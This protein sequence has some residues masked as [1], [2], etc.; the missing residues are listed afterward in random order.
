VDTNTALGSSIGA[1]HKLLAIKRVHHNK[2]HPSLF[3]VSLESL[4]TFHNHFSDK[5]KLHS[6]LSDEQG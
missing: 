5:R 1:E 4:L 3:D 2:K 6:S